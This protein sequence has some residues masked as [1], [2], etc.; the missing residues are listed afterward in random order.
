MTTTHTGHY[1]LDL[2]RSGGTLAFWPY[3]TQPVSIPATWSQPTL[4]FLY[5]VVQASPGNELLAIISAT[6]GSL[7][8][9]L[10]LAPGEWTH[11]WL[12]LSALSGQATTLSLGFRGQ[13]GTPQMAQQVYLDELS[14]GESRRGVYSTYLPLVLRSD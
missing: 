1:G 10:P 6:G 7:T 4:S 2:E 9:T 3:V 11:T 13:P 12:D 14:L 5:R 8:H